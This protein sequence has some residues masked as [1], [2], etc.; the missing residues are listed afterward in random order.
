MRVRVRVDRAEQEARGGA[1]EAAPR[2]GGGTDSQ[3]GADRRA[4]QETAGVR[5]RDVRPA[6]TA[7]EGQTEVSRSDA[8]LIRS[9]AAWR[10]YSLSF[11]IITDSKDS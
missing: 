5:Q 3:R 9:T 8:P 2:P 1:A 11:N 4:A 7:T 10:P 6:R